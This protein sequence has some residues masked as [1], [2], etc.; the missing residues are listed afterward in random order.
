VVG[1]RVVKVY[2]FFNHAQTQYFGIEI[3]VAFSVACYRSDVVDAV[4]SI[5]HCRIC[6]SVTG[7]A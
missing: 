3:V 4:Y 2:G 6:F 1:L 5:F 7:I